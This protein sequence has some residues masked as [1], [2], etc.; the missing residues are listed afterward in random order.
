M[1]ERTPQFEEFCKPYDQ[2]YRSG[3]LDGFN[4]GRAVKDEVMLQEH[5]ND[6][7]GNPA[8]GSTFGQGFAISWQN[9]PLG[10]G[11]G[12][13]QPNGAF[14]EHIIEAAVGRLEYYQESKFAC[15][16]NEQALSSLRTALKHLNDRTA[17][18]EKREVEG[19]HNE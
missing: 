4:H 3:Y 14:V 17:D 2:V 11:E 10:R 1:N 19:T 5:W 9:G 8:G 15:I 12:R 6:E 16:E 7:N 13:K 18:R